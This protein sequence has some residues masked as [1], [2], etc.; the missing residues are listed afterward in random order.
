LR[1]GRARACIR[2]TDRISSSPQ[3]P[4]ARLAVAGVV[5]AAVAGGAVAWALVAR[6]RDRSE[7][8]RVAASAAGNGAVD[9]VEEASIE[10]FPASD[11]PGWGGAGL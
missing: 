10:S 8:A 2:P 9:R 6:R 7:R 5:A 1:A 4:R 3:G 11:P